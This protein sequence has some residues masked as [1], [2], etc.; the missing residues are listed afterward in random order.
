MACSGNP[1]LGR[2]PEAVICF[3]I[4]GTAKV[5]KNGRESPWD[6]TLNKPVPR[7]I[8]MLVSDHVFANRRPES[9][10]LLS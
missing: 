2:D 10:A 5:F 9:I 8:G 7:L 4:K 6:A 3:G 1:I